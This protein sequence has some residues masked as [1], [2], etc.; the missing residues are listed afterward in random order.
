MEGD[1][2]GFIKFARARVKGINGVR[3]G[4]RLFA[5]PLQAD[6]VVGGQILQ[7]VVRKGVDPLDSLL[8][9]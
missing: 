8:G 7:I 9:N 2:A 3:F 5:H 1:F 6:L 4:L